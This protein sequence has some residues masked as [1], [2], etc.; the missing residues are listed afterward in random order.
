MG[1]RGQAPRIAIVG[2][3]LSGLSLALALKARKEFDGEVH[4]F[5]PREQYQHDRHWALWHVDAH[6][7]DHLPMVSFRHVEVRANKAT[8]VVDSDSMPYCVLNSDQV[9]DFASTSLADDLRFYLHMGT[10]VIDIA[11]GYGH[12]ELGM[13][14][15]GNGKFDLVFDS[16]ILS[17]PHPEA[18]RQWFIGAEVAITA[19]EKLPAPCLMDFC[20]DS[21]GPIG[22]FYVLPLDK[23]RVLVQLTYFLAPGEQPPEN[24]LAL[25]KDY[26]SGTLGLNAES[27]LREENGCIPMQTEKTVHKDFGHHAIGTA[28]GW[29]RA[30]TG[31]GFLDIQ[32]AASRIAEA[33]C[34]EDPNEREQALRRV[35]ARSLWD[36]RLDLI[37]LATLKREP[38]QAARFFSDIFR[39]KPSDQ[40][41]RFL[42]GSATWRDR[43]AVMRALPML[44]FLKSLLLSMK[45]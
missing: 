26:V 21:Q 28:A 1:N 45:P 41:L 12:L 27:I 10:S 2:A 14:W 34:I 22:F 11:A 20:L 30:S 42:S 23:N 16:R 9:Y 37:F 39:Q 35:S 6:R 31:Y 17:A 40:V 32:R 44:P 8:Y 25:W 36:D 5:E 29:V 7:Y 4:L 38:A 13:T 3:G 18:F 15:E 24:A 19:A 33:C 43:L